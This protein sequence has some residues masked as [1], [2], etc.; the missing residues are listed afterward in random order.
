[1]LPQEQLIDKWIEN[2]IRWHA[3]SDTSLKRAC[4]AAGRVVGSYNGST[5]VIAGATN[6]SAAT[7]E[8]WAHAW[9]L[10]AEI[11]KGVNRMRVR[12]LFRELPAS[13]WWLAYDIQRA[14]YDALYYLT[15]AHAHHY[16]GRE[17]L[18]EYAADREA[19]YAPM[20]F[21]RAASVLRSLADELDS[22]YGERLNRR[23]RAA[24]KAVREAF[25]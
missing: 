24:L 13:H 9:R 21:A 20:L 22:K 23:Q 8:N 2:I 5:G 19:G 3:D 10:Y 15:N 1:M 7:V 18:R 6:R 14:G 25:E 12:I 11:R 17:M 16:S 4:I